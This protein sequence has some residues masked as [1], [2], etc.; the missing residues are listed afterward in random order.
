MYGTSSPWN[1]KYFNLAYYSCSNFWLLQMNLQESPQHLGIYNEMSREVM[2]LL[3]GMLHKPWDGKH[4]CSTDTLRVNCV[5]CQNVALW[6]QLASQLMEHVCPR[7]P[8]KIPHKDLPKVYRDK[9]K[10]YQDICKLYQDICKLELYLF[11]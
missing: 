3:S 7:D 11:W 6:H 5:H 2:S 1:F 10:L 9:R 8:L 4:T